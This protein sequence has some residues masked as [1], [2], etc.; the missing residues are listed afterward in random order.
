MAVAM[1]MMVV[2]I[3]KR[4]QEASAETPTLAPGP[5][6]SMWDATKLYNIPRV[7]KHVM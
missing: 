4:F 5:I 2:L 3:L 6:L 7:H 1:V